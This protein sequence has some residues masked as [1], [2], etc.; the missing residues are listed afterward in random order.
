[1][2]ARYAKL[3]LVCGLA[4]LVSLVAFGN[5][6]DYGSNFAF[7]HHVLAMDTIFPDATIRYRAITAPWLQ[8]AAYALII[9]TQLATAALLWA[10]AWRMWL[11]RRAPAALFVRAKGLA[12]AGLSLGVL[13]W[14]VGFMAIGGEWF[15]MWMSSQWNGIETSFRLVALLLGALIYLGQN[16][17]EPE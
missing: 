9:A 14:L 6:T 3:L 5:L 4:L 17:A 7:V 15:G 16:E 8:H 10:G 11:R 12:T 13:L 1:M 2:P